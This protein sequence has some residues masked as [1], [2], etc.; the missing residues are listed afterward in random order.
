MG[1]KCK[2]LQ[3]AMGNMEVKTLKIKK[4]VFS[5]FKRNE[6]AKINIYYDSLIV[7][8]EDLL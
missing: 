7:N 4:L 8:I 1:F 3:D 5:L 2:D 6:Y